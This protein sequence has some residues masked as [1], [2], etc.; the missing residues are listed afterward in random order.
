MPSS[1]SCVLKPRHTYCT[2]AVLHR[3][4]AQWTDTD[5]KGFYHQFGFIMAL[6]VAAITIK[7]KKPQRWLKRQL[8]LWCSLLY[9]NNCIPPKVEVMLIKSRF[10]FSF[11]SYRNCASK[12]KVIC[13]MGSTTK[14]PYLGVFCC[15]YSCMSAH[16]SFK[17]PVLRWL[18]AWY[19]KAGFR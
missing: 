3:P 2:T 6:C 1:Q 8:T 11:L 4:I 14:R 18:H 12:R 17:V 7:T 19:T 16:F 5:K 15:V 10:K 13:E 9:T